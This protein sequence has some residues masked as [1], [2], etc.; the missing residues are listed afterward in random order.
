MFNPL[1]QALEFLVDTAFSLYILAILL[2]I[3]LQWVKADFYNPL[4]QA[5]IKITNPALLPLRRFI[6]GFFGMDWAAII[7]VFVLSII[8]QLILILLSNLKLVSVV[9]VL[10]LAVGDVLSLTFFIYFFALLFMVISSWFSPHSHNPLGMALRQIIAPVLTPIQRRMPA[11]A[12]MDFSPLVFMIILG[13]IYIIIIS[14]VKGLG[15]MLL[16]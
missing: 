16:S 11:V 6:P 14:P 1:L 5:L 2:R 3:L 7:L 10:A 8:N 12:G 15:Y 13:L 4:C 9:G